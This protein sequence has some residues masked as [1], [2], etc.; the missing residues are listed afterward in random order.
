MYPS[1]LLKY[2]RHNTP[3][4]GPKYRHFLTTRTL[5]DKLDLYAFEFLYYALPPDLSLEDR[6]HHAPRY[7]HNTFD[8]GLNFR[9]KVSLFSTT[10]RSTGNS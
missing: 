3:V 2:L 6:W 7:P 10:L 1:R 5:L 9:Y 8:S 4:S